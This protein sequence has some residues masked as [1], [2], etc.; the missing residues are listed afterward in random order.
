MNYWSE[1]SNGHIKRHCV[2][3]YY[4]K[5]VC[6]KATLIHFQHI[7]LQNGNMSKRQHSSISESCQVSLIVTPKVSEE[8]SILQKILFVIWIFPTMHAHYKT[9]RS[10]HW[11]KGQ[12]FLISPEHQNPTFSSN[13]EGKFS[14]LNIVLLIINKNQNC[15][16]H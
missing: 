16:L 9:P 5:Y 10:Y 11:I 1:T 3:R 15:P 13:F 12:F 4:F 7:S 14:P 8:D 2:R 6:L